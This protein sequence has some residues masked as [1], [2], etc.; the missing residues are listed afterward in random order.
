MQTVLIV[1]ALLA[2]L[3]ATGVCDVSWHRVL[4]RLRRWSLAFYSSHDGFDE[5]RSFDGHRNSRPIA[6]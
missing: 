6:A 2:I 3:V 1:M 4:A 5:P